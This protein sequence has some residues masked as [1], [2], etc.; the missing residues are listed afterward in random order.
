MLGDKLLFRGNDIYAEFIR[1]WTNSDYTHVAIC[2]GNG[3]LIESYPFVGVRVRDYYIREN[4]DRL[5]I[6]D[7]CLDVFGNGKEQKELYSSSMSWLLTQTGK[8]YS[9]V[10][11]FKSV[12]QKGKGIRSTNSWMCSNFCIQHDLN[13]GIKIWDDNILGSPADFYKNPF[14]NLVKKDNGYLE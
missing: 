4:F 3:K 10:D 2:L 6:T 5:R 1:W 14:Y 8:N 11:V 7:Q 13:S 12:V 9:W